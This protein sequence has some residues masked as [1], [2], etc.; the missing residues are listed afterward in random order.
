MTFFI[1]WISTRVL[2]SL[3]NTLRGALVDKLILY[4][5]TDCLFDAIDLSV[6]KNNRDFGRGFYT[7]TISSQAESWASSMKVR[8]HGEHAY[9]CE[10]EFV[11]CAGLKTLEFPGLTIE[12]LE[13]IKENRSLGGVQHDYDVVMGPVANDSTLLTVNR[14]IQG[15]Y[16]A[17][18]ALARLAYF[19]AND[20]VS[21]HTDQAIS[22]LMLKRRYCL[23]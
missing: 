14:Y 19:K 12:W 3:T 15:A 9:V 17:E 16:T 18:E 22:C 10:Y 13:F 1:R 20:Q 5:G 21:F 7:T 2:T 4:H 8:R 11:P 23:D 6:S